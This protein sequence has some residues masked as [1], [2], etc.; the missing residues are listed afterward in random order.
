MI[1]AA[2]AWSKRDPCLATRF[3]FLL[4]HSGLDFHIIN[5]LG[6]NGGIRTDWT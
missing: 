3:G 1:A 5:I 2:H 6:K 4:P